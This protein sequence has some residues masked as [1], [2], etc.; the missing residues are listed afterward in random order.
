MVILDWDLKCSL[1]TWETHICNH[2]NESECE[3][4]KREGHVEGH[5]LT[6]L[7]EDI[8]LTHS[9]DSMLHFSSRLLVSSCQIVVTCV[10]SA[11]IQDTNIINK[12]CDKQDRNHNFP[13]HSKDRQQ[14]QYIHHKALGILCTYTFKICYETYKSRKE[15]LTQVK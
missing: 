6:G 1:Q 15:N 12:S 9:W 8:V 2:C 3:S 14:V 4:K 10:A 7:G 13:W 11:T 5:G